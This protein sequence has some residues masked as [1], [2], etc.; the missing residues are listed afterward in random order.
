MRGKISPTIKQKAV[1]EIECGRL[2]QS[3]A[4]KRL[5]VDESTIRHCLSKYRSEGSAGLENNGKNRIYSVQTKQEAVEAYLT[6]RY[7][8]QKLYEIFK[9]RGAYQLR[10]WLKVYTFFHSH[11]FLRISPISFRFYP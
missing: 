10:D 8:L 1:T 4:A 7:S 6:G 11:S 5:G 3:E 9:I 2:S